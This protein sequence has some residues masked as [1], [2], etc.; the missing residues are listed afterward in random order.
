[1]VD[2]KL[3]RDI[4]D[5]KE[6]L[7][8][9]KSHAAGL[10]APQ[11][12]LN[13]RLFG[14]LSGNKKEMK[15]FINPRILATYGTKTRPMM[16]FDDGTHEPFLEGCLSFPDLFGTVKRFLKIEVVWDEIEGNKLKERRKTL[17]G[18]EAIVFQHESDHLDG[19]LFVDHILEEEGEL[20]RFVGDKKM[21]WAVEKVVEQEK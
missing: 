17:E 12:G 15:V 18:I 4:E 2:E 5:L 20:F 3:L 21:K 11:I 10:A 9:E 7:L 19:I 6:V 13:L 1:V 8:S 14:Q 16:T